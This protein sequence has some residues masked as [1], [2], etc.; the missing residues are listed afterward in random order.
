MVPPGS[1]AESCEDSL[2]AR[3]N[4]GP[5]VAA[6]VLHEPGALCRNQDLLFERWLQLFS[7]SILA[8]LCGSGR[9]F[10]SARGAQ[11]LRK[12]DQCWVLRQEDMMSGFPAQK[13]KGCT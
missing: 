4:S 3:L 8:Y 11:C 7:I 10:C 2:E 6:L 12:G 13:P 1:I 9:A 5:G